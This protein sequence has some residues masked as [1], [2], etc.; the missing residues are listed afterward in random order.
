MINVK[1]LLQDM[2]TS[3]A[4]GTNNEPDTCLLH[5]EFRKTPEWPQTKEF[6]EEND[7]EIRF[8]PSANPAKVQFLHSGSDRLP[9]FYH[10]AQTEDQIFGEGAGK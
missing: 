7:V 1:H 3:F 8:H 9:D 5:P 4:A 2:F 10:E 6:C